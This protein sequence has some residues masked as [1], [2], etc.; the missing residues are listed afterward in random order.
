MMR[1]PGPDGDQLRALR[2]EQKNLANRQRLQKAVLVQVARK[3]IAASESHEAR[4][5]KANKRIDTSTESRRGLVEATDALAAALTA[6]TGK[7]TPF[8]TAEEAAKVAEGIDLKDEVKL[9]VEEGK[10]TFNFFDTGASSAGLVPGSLAPSSSKVERPQ[11]LTIRSASSGLPS[12]EW[13]AKQV[14]LKLGP[15]AVLGLGLARDDT[16]PAVVIDLAALQRKREARVTKTIADPKAKRPKPRRPKKLY[17]LKSALVV[18]SVTPGSPADGTV[19][20]GDVLAS[21]NGTDVEGDSVDPQMLHRLG[22]SLPADASGAARDVAVELVL[23]RPE[24]GPKRKSSV[25]V[26]LAGK[27]VG[28]FRKTRV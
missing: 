7:T 16:L 18:A 17:E 25:V 9:V 15:N 12:S 22:E 26:R 11:Y 28:L 14:K 27:A 8:L 24:M 3:A 5:A 21:V 13:T 4:M 20:P 23:V 1:T 10:S 19:L 2:Y 6:L